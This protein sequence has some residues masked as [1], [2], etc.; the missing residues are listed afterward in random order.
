MV[1]SRYAAL[2][3]ALASY[4]CTTMETG[5]LQ[6]ELA[7]TISSETGLRAARD[8]AVDNQGNIYIFDYDDY[9]IR[10]FDAA[11]E[12]LRSFGGTGEEPGQFQH[13]MALEVHGDSLVALDPGSITVF[14]LSG[15]VRSRRSLADTVTCDHPRLHTDGRWAAACIV[16]ATAKYKLTYR[17]VD[18]RELREPA[19]FDLGE[20][21]PGVVPGGLFFI[22]RTQAPGYL[23]DFKPGGL[24][25][26]AASDNLR[27]LIDRAGMDETLFESAAEAVPFAADSITALRRRQAELGPP[28]FMNVPEQY[29]LIQHLVVSPTG[30]IWLNVRS[31]ER[32]GLLRLSA[33]GRE[34]GFYTIDRQFEESSARLAL[35]N[36]RL[37][38]MTRTRDETAVYTVELP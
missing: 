21:F 4:G 14:D 34:V 38:I 13:L 29:Q 36:G 9:V 3:V 19:S 27:V 17:G 25:V 18:G 32:T 7:F 22:G 35:A 1:L 12:L 8:L 24:L 26:W 37:Y 6:V 2:T 30:D 20:Y 33:T 15:T 23:Y 10:K 16:E 5:P 28:L 31:Q 11:G